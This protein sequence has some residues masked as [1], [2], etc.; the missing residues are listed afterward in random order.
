M[1]IKSELGDDQY[2]SALTFSCRKGLDFVQ[3]FVSSSS[4]LR[5]VTLTMI[6]VVSQQLNREISILEAEQF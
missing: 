3:T 5:G 6:L 2:S 1:K 4:S